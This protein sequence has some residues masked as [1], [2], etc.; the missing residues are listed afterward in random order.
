MFM[1]SPAVRPTSVRHIILWLTVLLYMV[2][3]FDRVM[4]STAMPEIQKEFGFSTVTVGWIFAA[5]QISYALFQIPGG[6]LGDY[7]GPRKML[8][9]IVLWWSA[10]TAFTAMAWSLSSMVVCRF[11]FGM[12]EAGAFPNATRSLSRWMLPAERGWA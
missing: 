6:W 8:T 11:L 4:I 9:Y 12:G 2:T 7:I 3:Y 10:F 1:S 5:F